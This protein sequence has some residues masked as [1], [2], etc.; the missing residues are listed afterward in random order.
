MTHIIMFTKQRELSELTGL[1]PKELVIEGFYSGNIVVGFCSAVEMTGI[2]YYDD[3]EMMNQYEYAKDGFE[4]LV[5]NM[6][7]SGIGYRHFEYKEKHYYIV[8]AQE[9]F[10]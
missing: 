10:T 8:Y 4:W 2:D 3:G 9:D 6:D 7:T 5:G 1:S